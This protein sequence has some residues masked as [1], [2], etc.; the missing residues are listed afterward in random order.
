MDPR[1]G[2]RSGG[3]PAARHARPAWH[4][5]RHRSARRRLRG[6]PVH[7]PPPVSGP[8]SA[9]LRIA[10]DTDATGPA[11]LDRPLHYF[12]TGSAITEVAADSLRD[13]RL[14]FGARPAGTDLLSA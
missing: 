9:F 4:V 3:L 7:R 1:P 2:H 11:L 8:M 13:H 5:R 6:A 10:P 12:E 14:R